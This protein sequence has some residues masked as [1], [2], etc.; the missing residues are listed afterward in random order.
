M[1]TRRVRFLILGAVL[2]ALVG[3][4][5]KSDARVEVG[6]GMNI[7]VYTFAA[8]P[9]LVVIPGTYAYYVP[10]INMDVLF[11]HG[12]WYRPFEGR[13]F[14]ARDYNGPW[15]FI[16]VGSV[17]RVLIGLPPGYRQIAGYRRIPY[18]E[19][20]GNWRR[21]ERN[22]YWE[23]DEWWRSGVHREHS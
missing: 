9:P 21:W 13:W 4:S 1:K 12:Y 2:L 17:P 6:V 23:K 16:A 14:R 20:S 10:D 8:P 18:G 15:G 19:F 22:R 11:Y 5:V 3:S 7:P